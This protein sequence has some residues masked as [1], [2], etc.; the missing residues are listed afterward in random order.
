VEVRDADDLKVRKL[1]RDTTRCYPLGKVLTNILF[2]PTYTDYAGSNAQSH[3][4]F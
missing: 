3:F 4:D 2:V 1:K